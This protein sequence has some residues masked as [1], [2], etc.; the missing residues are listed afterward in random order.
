[1]TPFIAVTDKA[2]FDF[3]SSRARNGLVDEVNFWS[4]RATRPMKRMDPGEPVML[5]LKHPHNAIAGYG[6]FA[7]FCALELD[8]A[9]DLFD[10]KNGDE[11]K[12]RFLERIGRYRQLSLIDPRVP[13]DPLGCTLLRNVIF[14]PE[15]RWLPWGE[16]MGWA[17][18]IV[19][20]KSENDPM[21]GELLLRALA[22]DAPD[23]IEFKADSFKP[24]VADERMIASASQVLRE[25]QGTFRARLL[26]VYDG[27]CAITGEHT[28][29]VLDAAHIQPYLG[30]RSNHVQNGLVL[31]KEFHALF[32]RGYV[33][34]TPDY[35]VRVSERLRSD[36]ANGKRYYPY[37]GAKLV[38]V[39]D[40]R[41]ARPS[42]EALE[43]HAKRVFL[44]V[45]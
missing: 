5:R 28:Q 16:E 22:E 26:D 25:G 44:D 7:H 12:L 27:R 14:W 33:T 31:T 30:P 39:P 18:N 17:K 38:H 13:R 3:L 4:P 42:P 19:Q 40:D 32:D 8:R 10:W 11:D 29:P 45:A 21:R 43:W 36:W 20:G 6:F 1:M 37:D 35:V 2:W 34:I 9:W 23:E 41:R 24:L 15:R